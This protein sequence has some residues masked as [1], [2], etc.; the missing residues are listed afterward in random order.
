MVLEDHFYA[1]HPPLDHRVGGHDIYIS[2]VPVPLWITFYG[3]DEITEHSHRP[4][5]GILFK[6]YTFISW[7]NTVS[8]VISK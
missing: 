7:I 3:G 1:Q 2:S 6:L 4:F 8:G 5:Q